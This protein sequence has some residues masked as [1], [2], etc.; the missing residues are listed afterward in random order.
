MLTISTFKIISSLCFLFTGLYHFIPKV[1]KYNKHL[2]IKMRFYEL[3]KYSSNIFLV[4]HA[5]PPM[6]SLQPAS[7]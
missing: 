1:A 5:N 3:K 7:L 2:A 4:N 6:H